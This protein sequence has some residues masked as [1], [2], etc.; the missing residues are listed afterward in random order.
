[1]LDWKCPVRKCLRSSHSWELTIH[2]CNSQAAWRYCAF[3][4]NVC[5]WM[6]SSNTIPCRIENWHKN[7]DVWESS[8]LPR[9]ETQSWGHG[10]SLAALCSLMSQWYSVLKFH[11]LRLLMERK[12]KSEDYMTIYSNVFKDEVTTSSI[13]F[14][15][16]ALNMSFIFVK[17]PFPIFW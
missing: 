4:C 7:P 9:S 3:F 8:T 12:V 11:K 1:M 13:P 14:L 10:W 16:F 17:L 15:N 6:I 5:C 2:A